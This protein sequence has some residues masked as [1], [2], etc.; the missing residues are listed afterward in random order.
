MLGRSEGRPQVFPFY[1]IDFSEMPAD[2]PR[3]VSFEGKWVEDS[4]E[5][6]GTKPV[7]C[8]NL[9]PELSERIA[10]TALSAFEALE[11]RD[12]A[13]VDIRLAADGIPYV[14]DVNPNCD[15]S[16]V[17]GGFSKAAKAAG[18]SY[19]QVDPA[20]C[21]ARAR[22]QAERRYHPAQCP[23][24]HRATPPPAGAGHRRWR[25]GRARR[26]QPCTLGLA[27]GHRYGYPQRV[28]IPSGGFILGRAASPGVPSQGRRSDAARRGRAAAAR[29]R[30]GDP[31]GHHAAERDAARVG[32]LRSTSRFAARAAGAERPVRFAGCGRAGRG[33]ARARRRGARRRRGRGQGRRARRGPAAVRYPAVGCAGRD[34]GGPGRRGGAGLSDSPGKGGCEGE[35]SDGE[36]HDGTRRKGAPGRRRHAAT[37][38]NRRREAGAVRAARAAGRGRSHRQLRG[39]REAGHGARIR[40]SARRCAPTAASCRSRPSASPASASCATRCRRCSTCWKTPTNRCA[41]PR[42]AR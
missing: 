7:R 15:L 13:R 31:A 35:R 1:E 33:G 9:T 22:A 30:R 39:A 27:A 38:A 40:R 17:A 18:L 19:E 42:W 32:R 6:R 36:S 12:Y 21:R 14:I 3:I 29:A 37:S 16:D 2:R 26:P 41:T 20:D 28:A 5:Y 25:C 23:L 24:A 34:R 8:T 11:L 10:N 4:D